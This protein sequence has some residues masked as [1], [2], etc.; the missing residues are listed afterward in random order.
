M[1]RSA[2]KWLA[3][4][5]SLTAVT[6]FIGANAHLLTVALRSQPECREAAGMMP[7]KRAC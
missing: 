2:Q 1:T 5:A 6:L 4:G 7:A 3:I